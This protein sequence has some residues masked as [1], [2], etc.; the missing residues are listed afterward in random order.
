MKFDDNLKFPHLVGQKHR[1]NVLVSCCCK[2]CNKFCSLR[3][4]LIV[5]LLRQ[6]IFIQKAKRPEVVKDLDPN[7]KKRSEV[8]PILL[9]EATKLEED[10]GRQ[11]I[12]S[13][14]PKTTTVPAGLSN[15][16]LFI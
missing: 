11:Q 3:I 16:Q 8:T 2:S 5:N 7:S 6:F 1:L 4:V 10:E 13:T 15:I 9:R 14:F 12:K